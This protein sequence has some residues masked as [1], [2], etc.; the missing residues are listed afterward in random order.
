MLL[1]CVLAELDNCEDRRTAWVSFVD[2]VKPV[3]LVHIPRPVPS[4]FYRP[5]CRSP[6]FS[7][8]ADETRDVLSSCTAKPLGLARTQGL[9]NLETPNMA[10][11]TSL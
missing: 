6:L 10:A 11:V 7:G 5:H 3:L 4:V 9:L 8:L 1:H 2:K